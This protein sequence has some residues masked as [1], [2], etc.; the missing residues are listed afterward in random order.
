MERKVPWGLMERR[1]RMAAGVHKEMRVAWGRKVHREMRGRMGRKV[2]MAAEV[3][4]VPEGMM[5]RMV[6]MV[7]WVHMAGGGS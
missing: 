6:Q 1:G 2:Q 5:G 3:P 4:W 7:A